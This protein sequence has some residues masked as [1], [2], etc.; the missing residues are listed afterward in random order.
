FR[1]FRSDRA[2]LDKACDQRMIA[3]ELS[4]YASADQQYAAVANMRKVETL[5][6]K[7]AG[8]ERCSHAVKQR[9]GSRFLLQSEVCIVKCV[10]HALLRVFILRS[11]IGV[12]DRFHR[13]PAGILAALGA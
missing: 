7:G 9:L 3:G 10:N 12:A 11:R 6:D 2:T 1:I 13:N 8:S 4:R 5:A